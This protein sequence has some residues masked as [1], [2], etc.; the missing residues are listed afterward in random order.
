M[1]IVAIISKIPMIMNNLA[2][3]EGGLSGQLAKTFSVIV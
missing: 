3:L 1:K 2:Y